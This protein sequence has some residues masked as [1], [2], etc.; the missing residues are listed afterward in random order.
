[1]IIIQ[2]AGPVSQNV[3]VFVPSIKDMSMR[4]LA[5]AAV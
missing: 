5:A 3:I 1:M 4:Q 2:F